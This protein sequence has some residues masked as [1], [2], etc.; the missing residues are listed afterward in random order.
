MS[1]SQFVEGF[2]RKPINIIWDYHEI[3]NDQESDQT[4]ET[5]IQVNYDLDTTDMVETKDFT[6]EIDDEC[7]ILSDIIDHLGTDDES[8]NLIESIVARDKQEHDGTDAAT[9]CL[10]QQLQK[11]CDNEMKQEQPEPFQYDEDEFPP[12]GK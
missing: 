9:L 8:K 12:L 1:S 7:Q 11:D 2:P 5:V 6:L 3:K 10:V 4:K